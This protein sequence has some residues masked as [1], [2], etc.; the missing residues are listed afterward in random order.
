MASWSLKSDLAHVILFYPHDLDR[1]G[2]YYQH[3]FRDEATEHKI[4]W[5][6]ILTY[7]VSRT[8]CL[9]FSLIPPNLNFLPI[10]T[11]FQWNI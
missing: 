1:K 10:L 6:M 2:K 4:Y 5:P 7:L 11:T 9:D 8:A 3:T